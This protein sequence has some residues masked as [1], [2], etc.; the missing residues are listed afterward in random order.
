MIAHP[1]RLSVVLSALLVAGTAGIA[2]KYGGHFSP[3][4]TAQA[5]EVARVPKTEVD[6]ATVVF[7]SVSEWQSYSGRLEAVGKV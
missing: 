5:A 7:K 2:V 1:K 3:V 4:S 6:V